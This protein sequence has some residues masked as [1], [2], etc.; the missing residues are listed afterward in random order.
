MVQITC[1]KAAAIAQGRELLTAH[2]SRIVAIS[3]DFSP[4]WAG[5]SKT[6]VFTDGVT[7]VDVLDSEWTD[8]VATHIP[9]EVLTTAGRRVRVGVYGTDGENVVLP[10]VWA[11][12]GTVL[13]GADP[14]GDESTDPTLPVWAQLQKQLE[15]IGVTPEE[16]QAAVE[17]YLTENPVEAPVT[18]VNGKTGAVELK[19]IDVSAVAGGTCHYWNDKRSAEQYEAGFDNDVVGMYVNRDAGVVVCRESTQATN[20]TWLTA[21]LLVRFAN[22]GGSTAYRVSVYGDDASGKS[23]T[24]KIDLRDYSLTDPVEVPSVS[25]EDVQT[26]Q[27]TANE[28]K[29]AAATAQTTAD[30][31]KTAAANVYS[32]AE[33]DAIMGSYINDIDALVGGDA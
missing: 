16:V 29:A 15:G 33:I 6:A 13:R 12:L 21:P 10:T 30:E 26:A 17:A 8:G 25:I 9:H 31:A 14:S 20:G 22:E 3:F 24:A 11:D 28:A 1:S 19:A 23:F 7:T 27:T 2:M 18:S 5:L 32:K 4:E